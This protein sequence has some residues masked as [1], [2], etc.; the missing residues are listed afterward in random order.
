MVFLSGCNKTQSYGNVIQVS[1]SEYKDARVRTRES[2]MEKI[3]VHILN[4]F[5]MAIEIAFL[6]KRC[7]AFAASMHYRGC[8]VLH[9]QA[10]KRT[11]EVK[12]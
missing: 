2:K 9:L 6:S 8:L 4:R 12:R 10:A 1:R 5:D 3:F 7:I 11:F